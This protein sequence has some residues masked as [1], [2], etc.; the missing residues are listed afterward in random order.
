M[1]V[2][3][4]LVHSERGTNNSQK[5]FKGSIYIALSCLNIY[6]PQCHKIS[7]TTKLVKDAVSDVN[8]LY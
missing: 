5:N 6:F 2:G 4:L 1:L 7:T 3:C 8:E